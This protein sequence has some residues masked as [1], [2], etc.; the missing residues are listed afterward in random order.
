MDKILYII[1]LQKVLLFSN[2]ELEAATVQTKFT[3][4]I[5]I[6][7]LLHKIIGWESIVVMQYLDHIMI[8]GMGWPTKKL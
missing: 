3:P 8:T 1:F 5:I 7:L 6:I 4:G 2:H